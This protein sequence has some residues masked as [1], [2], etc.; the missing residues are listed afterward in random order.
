MEWKRLVKPSYL[1]KDLSLVAVGPEAGKK[2]IFLPLPC[3]SP[4][5]YF[6]ELIICLSQSGTRSM[7]ALT[8]MGMSPYREASESVLTLASRLDP[9]KLSSKGTGFPKMAWKEE[10][11]PQGVVYKRY[12]RGE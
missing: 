10:L 1:Y 12:A 6:F 2:A 7:R 8:R 4:K 3:G 9:I 5:S 11:P